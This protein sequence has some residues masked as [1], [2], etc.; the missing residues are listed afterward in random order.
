MTHRILTLLGTA[1]L[2]SLAALSPMPLAAQGTAVVQPL[3]PAASGELNR[4][5]RRLDSNPRDVDALIMAAA[6]S[7]ELDDID[8]AIGFYGRADELSPGNPR[9]KA[10]TAAAYVRVQ[11]P[12]E[13][14]RLFDEAE[15]AGV[16]PISMAGD[17]GLAHDLVGNNRDA[18]LAY[19]RALS[20]E[21]DAEIR[22]RMALSYAISGDREAFEST[23]LPLLEQRDF[24]AYRTRSFGLAILG[25][26][27]EGIAIA[28]AVMPREMAERVEP[29]LRYMRRLTPAQQ[30][31]AANLGI[32]PRAAAIGR[33]DPRIVAAREA[34]SAPALA[35]VD[36]P[37]AP[38]GRP[39]GQSQA[40]QQTAPQARQ[41]SQADDGEDD[42]ARLT[43][44]QRQALL[45]QRRQRGRL[46]S[47]ANRQVRI[48]EPEPAP[49]E[50]QAAA[51]AVPAAPTSPPVQTAS[52]TSAPSP[53]S[54]TRPA[55]ERGE[56]PALAAGGEL[57]PVGAAATVT[58]PASSDPSP[59]QAQTSTGTTPAANQTL[60]RVDVAPSSAGSS[61][62]VTVASL[63][64]AT[65]APG[66][67]LGQAAAQSTA[68]ANP[69]TLPPSNTAPAQRPVASVSDAFADLLSLPDTSEQPRPGNAVDITA[70]EIPREEAAAPEPAAAPP[71]PEKPANVS[72]IWVQVATGRDRSA[73]KFDWRR[74]SRQAPEV[75]DDNGPFVASWGETNRLLAGPFSSRSAANSAVSALSEQ[76]IDA[77]RF[78]S[79]N[80]EEIEELD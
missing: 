60:A 22:R 14:L 15:R 12:V 36:T 66:F 8:A 64:A 47:R 20:F 62:P 25:E 80:G 69:I 5:L 31:A 21:E 27:D 2:G 9:V 18:Q 3:P 7:L 74:L 28:D 48:A 57:P 79:A 29:Y 38:S 34:G 13:A 50:Q 72:R 32:F 76:G 55:T 68:P 41:T 10:G 58:P 17:K 6:A 77:F 71:E 24:A 26:P 30:A 49:A 78:T 67:D 51:A 63:P 4:A 54:A 37:L 65:P 1:G 56:L 46:P 40:A 45:A 59:A 33:D 44:E 53:P 61:T 39:L 23:L 52:N 73:L 19:R 11:R 70:I 42:D 35:A 75:L 16:R 43:R